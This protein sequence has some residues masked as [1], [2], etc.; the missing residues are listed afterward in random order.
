LISIIN[1]FQAN[2]ARYFKGEVLK[3]FCALSYFS[4]LRDV[5]S[6]PFGCYMKGK[7]FSLMSSSP[8][9]FLKI[10]KGHIETRPIKGT[11]SD[12][13]GTEQ[14]EQSTKDRAEN[15]MIVDML[16]NDLAK[17]SKTLF[18]PELIFGILLL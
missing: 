14:L 6:A 11:L 3:E 10:E 15:I 17:S 2:I 4:Q 13:F 5:N 1:I 18:G 7:D 8:E 9:R 16:R 12:H